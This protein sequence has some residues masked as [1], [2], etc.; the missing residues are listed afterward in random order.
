ME[1]EKYYLKTN[2]MKISSEELQENVLSLGNFIDYFGINLIPYDLKNSNIDDLFCEFIHN[3]DNET[4]LGFFENNYDYLVV[5]D[6]DFEDLK[7]LNNSKLNELLK[8][9]Y[10]DFVDYYSIEYF[11]YFIIT[12]KDVVLFKKYCNYDIQYDYLKDLYILCIDHLGTSW[13]MIN[14]KYSLDH[15]MD[16]YM[17]DNTNDIYKFLDKAIKF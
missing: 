14:T 10:Y 16:N 4:I 11:Q 5:G 13:Y 3:Y 7:N 8:Y 12:E 15:L 9:N 2:I 1:N 6:Y 17:F